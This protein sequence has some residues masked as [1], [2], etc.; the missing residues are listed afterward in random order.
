MQAR[1]T[2]TGLQYSSSNSLPPVSEVEVTD[3]W[4]IPLLRRSLCFLKNIG[5]FKFSRF[6]FTF[7]KYVNKTREIARIFLKMSTNLAKTQ[8]HFKKCQ[9]NLPFQTNF[10][11]NFA[12]C[13]HDFVTWTFGNIQLQIRRITWHF[14]VLRR[15]SSFQFSVFFWWLGYAQES[16]VLG[17]R[18]TPDLTI[19]NRLILAHD[20]VIDTQTEH[21]HN[22]F[23]LRYWSLITIIEV[24]SNM[25]SNSRFESNQVT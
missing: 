23:K 9:Q 8:G 22:C 19:A 25:A 7:L 10:S 11:A 6:L 13:W 5:N 3:W 16:K 1:Q 21:K 20:D 12:S 14:V 4:C 24:S 18:P 15:V 2:S 17:V